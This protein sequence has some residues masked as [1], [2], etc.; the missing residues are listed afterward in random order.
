MKTISGHI[1]NLADYN[2]NNLDKIHIDVIDIDNEKYTITILV[3]TELTL[4][5]VIRQAEFSMGHCGGIA[6]CASCHCYIE[7]KHKLNDISIE[8]GDMLDQLHNSDNSKSR[9]ICQIPLTKE[10]DG[11]LLRIVPS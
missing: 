6:L 5:D 7:K 8:E 3:D 11:I 1:I 4:M 2:P 9:L 10:L